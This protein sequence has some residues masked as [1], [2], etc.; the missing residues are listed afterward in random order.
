VATIRWTVRAD[1]DLEHIH[2]FIA[3]TSLENA[4]ILAANLV[5]AVEPLTDFPSLGRTVPEFADRGLREVLVPPYRI[6]Y[7]ILEGDV[8]EV[9]G[10]Y[11]S[12]RDLRRHLP[13]DLVT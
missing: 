6:V 8:I 10:I 1:L 13:D 12:S 3:R 9:E 11:H 5:A 2:R 7:A 4:A